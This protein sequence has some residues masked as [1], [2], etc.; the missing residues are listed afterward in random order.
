[1]KRHES[2]VVGMI[3]S[4]PLPMAG[5]L[6]LGLLSLKRTDKVGHKQAIENR[7]FAT[8]RSPKTVNI[9]TLYQIESGASCKWI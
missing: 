8:P 5:G 1:M 9:N 4:H 2:T 7:L 3:E 6:V